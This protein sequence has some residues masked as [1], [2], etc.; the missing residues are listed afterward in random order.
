MPQGAFTANDITGR[1]QHTGS[2]PTQLG[3]VVDGFP[4]VTAWLHAVT[5]VELPDAARAVVAARSHAL[6]RLEPPF[7]RRSAWSVDITAGRTFT[8]WCED[9]T[10][11]ATGD[12][13]VLLLGI[14]LL[15]R[16]MLHPW[17]GM[18]A[19]D[20]AADAVDLERAP[21]WVGDG[22]Q[23]HIDVLAT[24][25]RIGWSTF[26]S[27]PAQVSAPLVAGERSN[28][29]Q[30]VTLSLDPI[31]VELADDPALTAFFACAAPIEWASIAE[32]LLHGGSLE[33]E[34]TPADFLGV[35]GTREHHW[36][37]ATFDAE[38]DLTST[39]GIDWGGERDE[40]LP[41]LLLLLR[42]IAQPW[43]LCAIDGSDEQDAAPPWVGRVRKAE[44]L[45]A[46]Q[47]EDPFS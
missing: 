28:G 21:A 15:L 25:R 14:E 46:W 37:M 42:A 9:T 27:S 32:Q 12:S 26:A 3:V 38:V 18:L 4:A 29:M 39:G 22:R 5:A 1:L 35:L 34:P 17:E 45:I 11:T 6:E 16:A 23:A 10:K 8:V 24:L 33:L 30:Q 43:H 44:A 40:L 13:R 7:P 36:T 41:P 31:A 47:V 20:E 19:V 2:T